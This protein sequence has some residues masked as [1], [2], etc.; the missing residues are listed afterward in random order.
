MCFVDFTR[1]FDRVNRSIQFYNFIKLG[2]SARLIDTES[3]DQVKRC[4][5]LPIFNDTSVS[6]CSVKNGIHF[7]KYMSDKEQKLT[8]KLKTHSLQ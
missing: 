2:W 8:S 7:H 6:Q 5:V 1:T 4:I 3:L